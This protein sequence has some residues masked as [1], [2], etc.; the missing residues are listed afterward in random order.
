M[1]YGGISLEA[2]SGVGAGF[3]EE[4]LG[5]VELLNKALAAGDQRGGAV[6]GLTTASGAPLKVESLDKTLKVVTFK[7]QNIVL[8]KELPVL[9]AYN[10]VEEY[11]RLISYGSDA[12]AF[13]TEGELPEEQDSIY[14]RKSE[15]VRYLGNTRVVT[16]PMTLVNAAHGDVMTREIENGT[17]WILQ[18]LEQGLFRSDNDLIPIQF[19]SYPVQQKKDFTSEIEWLDSDV[20]VDCR[21]NTLDE[22]TMEL[23][24]NA[25]IENYGFPTDLYGTPRAISDFVKTFYPKQRVNI[26]GSTSGEQSVGLK[27]TSFVSTAGTVNLKP[28]VFLRN[29]ANRKSGDAATSPKAPSA[30][31]ADPS[32]PVAAV[33][34]TVTNTK[35]GSS[36]AG[37]YL[38]GVTAV[39]RYGESAL[40]VLSTTPTTIASGGAADLKFTAGIGAYPPTAYRIYR[41]AKNAAYSAGQ[42][43]FYP[44]FDIS[45]AQLAAGYMG[46]S[47]GLVRDLNRY[48][49]DTTK[50]ILMQRDLEVLS[51]KQLA[52]LMKM[53]LAVLSPAFRFMVLLYGTPILYAPRKMVTFI[54][55]GKNIQSVAT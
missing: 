22:A 42:N 51:F 7:M 32:A 52:P 40:T 34:A 45:A 23:G 30:P 8:W 38:W 15:L 6:E 18:A 49:P 2:Y 17:I 53:D 43:V 54:N 10:T 25:I 41:A 13:I 28:D 50:A 46:A 11:N 26:P 48:L 55:V 12:G 44:L 36:D 9:P 20:V 47:A 35:W 31:I 37:D 39:N 33:A 27:V 16:H 3:G 24:S 5:N 1:N 21:G 4:T 14:V 19:N 29:Y